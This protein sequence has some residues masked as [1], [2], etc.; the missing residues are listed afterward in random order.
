MKSFTIR[1]I[2]FSIVVVL[3]IFFSIYFLFN[4]TANR[5]IDESVEPYLNVVIHD[6]LQTEIAQFSG[7]AGWRA[8]PMQEAITNILDLPSGATPSD[9]LAFAILT[10]SVT[11][12]FVMLNER[13]IMFTS[14]N[15]LR[16][17]TNTE[18]LEVDG[19][20][21]DKRRFFADYYRENRR[22]FEPNVKKAV[23]VDGR[24]F[25]LK[26]IQ[27]DDLNFNLPPTPITILFFAEATELL[28][29]R[30]SVNQVLLG[31]LT[32]GAAT[33]LA[34]AFRMTL[35]FNHAIT[36]L[37]AYAKKIG[38]GTFDAK[39]DP[40]YHTE[41]QSI[42]SSMTDMSNML[43]TYEVNQK[44]FFQNASHELRT[45]LMAVQCYSEG[46]LAE[47]FEPNDAAHIINFEIEKMTEL[48]N[49]ILY[50]SRIDH[51]AVSLEPT[52]VDEF[53][54][55]CYDQVKILAEN[56]QKNI[57]YKPLEKDFKINID[58]ALL[59]RAVL[60]ILTNALRYVDT[61]IIISTEE[62]LNRNIFMNVRQEMIR[63]HIFNNG[64]HINEQ[65]LP[66]VFDRFY[67]GKGGNTGI[68]LSITREIIQAFGGSVVA[69]NVENG[70]RFTI[71]LPIYKGAPA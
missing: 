66:H 46:I 68:G 12:N 51:H 1:F 20:S 37:S 11:D 31:I 32:I 9:S 54:K 5:F 33:I 70:V 49:S 40:L 26:S 36:K 63:I 30:D 23:V 56:N 10:D 41:F 62:Y 48:V 8:I 3:I 35:S 4:Q 50:L 55:E 71:E 7:R 67:K 25:Y 15:V 6:N 45:P 21:I 53:L 64:E 47:V 39:I 14:G 18:F 44:Q 42:S 24:T 22:S 58:I 13:G 61:E 52:S 38:R 59:D 69:E 65:D 16:L 2:T 34:I 57:I 17:N 28:A 27:Q 60:N 43:A 29:F 19:Q